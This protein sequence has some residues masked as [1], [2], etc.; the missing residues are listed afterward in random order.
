MSI[1]CFCM[2]HSVFRVYRNVQKLTERA[3][4]FW[5][6]VRLD[7]KTLLKSKHGPISHYLKHFL[8]RFSIPP[9]QISHLLI[10]KGTAAAHSHLIL[11]IPLVHNSF[12]TCKHAR[13]HINNLVVNFC[14]AFIRCFI[15]FIE[16]ENS[17]RGGAQGVNKRDGRV[18]GRGGAHIFNSRR[19]GRISK[20]RD[21]NDYAHLLIDTPVSSID[22][23]QREGLIIVWYVSRLSILLIKRLL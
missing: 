9:R 16:D 15:N 23:F 4:V 19:D 5:D 21:P 3:T 6:P 20:P 12:Y 14:Y 18:P 13:M 22:L 2:L 8:S 17:S 7:E 10:I 11:G 1:M